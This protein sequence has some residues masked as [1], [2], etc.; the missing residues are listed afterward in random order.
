M[1][2]LSPFGRH[3]MMTGAW[4]TPRMIS[5]M[6]LTLKRVNLT[7]RVPALMG[8]AVADYMEHPVQQQMYLPQRMLFQEHKLGPTSRAPL[9]AAHSVL[10][11]L[12]PTGAREVVER[13]A[14]AQFGVAH[15]QG[16]R[17]Q[18][19][20]RYSL[21]MPDD[22]PQLWRRPVMGVPQMAAR[23]R[24]GPPQSLQATDGRRQKQAFDRARAVAEVH[25]S[26]ANHDLA[27]R[28][29]FRKI[30]GGR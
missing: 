24:V 9:G 14:A 20:A 4:N 13:L 16:M 25:A 2:W 30:V 29:G 5:T 12:T 23:D 17:Q 8:A 11:A 15:G 22:Q 10:A 27:A 18:G 21:P 1:N 6:P 3:S 26:V 7:T 19:R 28:A